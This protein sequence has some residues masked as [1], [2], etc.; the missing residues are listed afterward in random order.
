MRHYIA[1]I[2]PNNIFLTFLTQAVFILA[3]SRTSYLSI[4]RENIAFPESL[5]IMLAFCFTAAGGYVINDLFDVDIDHINRP[6][7]RIIKRHISHNSAMAYYIVLTIAGQV[8]AYFA[9]LGVGILLTAIA[10]LLYFYSSDLKAMGLPGNLLIALISGSVIYVASRGINEINRGYFAEYTFLA[11]LLT[12]SRELIK[13][14]EDIEGD[15][16]QDCETF[17]IVHGTKKTNVLSNVVLGTI[18]IFLGVASY[19]LFLEPFLNVKTPFQTAL[20]MF[21]T[22]LTAI[23]IPMLLRGMYMTAKAENKR[24]YKKISKLLKLTMFVGLISVLFS[25]P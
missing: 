21:P 7:K 11:F 25:Q 15:K 19:I 14:A 17:P 20:L 18:V 2:R 22:Y 3:A 6:N 8:F 12:F 16:Q 9:G 23:L 10:I 13:D 4:D 5:F 24:D 1:I